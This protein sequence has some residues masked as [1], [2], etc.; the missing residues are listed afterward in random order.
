MRVHYMPQWLPAT[1]EP[2]KK[3]AKAR[4]QFTSEDAA[5]TP[6]EVYAPRPSDILD[7]DEEGQHTDILA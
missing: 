7:E 5:E 3:L 2:T 6:S 1:F 4:K